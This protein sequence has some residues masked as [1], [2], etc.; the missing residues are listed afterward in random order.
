ML[1]AGA[2]S[3][4]VNNITDMRNHFFIGRRLAMQGYSNNCLGTIESDINYKANDALL[5][6]CFLVISAV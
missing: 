4:E 3:W 2:A 6:Q 5:M 1:S